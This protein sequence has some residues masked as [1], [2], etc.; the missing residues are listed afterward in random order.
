MKRILNSLI[1]L[2]VILLTSMSAM[3]TPKITLTTSPVSAASISQGSNYNV[4]YIVKA[5]VTVE[6]VTLNLIAFT[7]TGT[8]DSNDFTNFYIYFNPTSPSMTGATYLGYTPG[9]F[10]GPHQF[11]ANISKYMAANDEG[12]FLISGNVSTTATD[13]NTAQVNGATNPVTFT[14][15]TI[16]TIVNNQNNGAGVQ[17]IEAADV[18]LSSSVVDAATIAQGSQYNKVYAAK[19][20]VKT[21]SVVVNSIQFTLK[22]NHDDNDLTYAYVYFNPTSP[23][24]N[25]A[26]YLGYATANFAGPHTYAVSI[27]KAMNK[28]DQGYFIISVTLSNTATDEHTVL[29]NGA[30]DPV[31]FGYSTAPNVTN[32]QSNKS[33]TQT[34]QAADVTLTSSVIDSAKHNQ[35]STYNVMYAVKASVKTQPVTMN[36][37]QFTV[38]GTHD[39]GDLTY[40]YVYFNESSPDMTGASYLGYAYANYSAPHTYTVGINKAMDKGESGYFIIS[41]SLTND[42]TDGHTFLINGASNPVVFT[43]TTGPNVTDKQSNKA[44]KQTI[45]AADIT[46]T[47]SNVPAADHNQG[48]TYNVFYTTKMV[49]KTQPVT[50]NNIQFNLK[51]S[52]DNGDL[53]YVYVY[54]NPTSPDMTGASYLGYAYANFSGPH[55]YS[56]NINK[57]MAK[58]DQGYFILSASLTNNATD[59]HTFLM[60]GG[61]DPVV[62]GFNTAPNITNNQSNKSKKQT[63][64]AADITLTTPTI[65]AGNIAQGSTYNEVYAAKMNV[66]TEPVTVTNVQFTLSGNHDNNDLTYVYVYYNASAPEV[67]GGTYLGYATATYAA[68]HTYSVGINK[69]MNAGDQGYFI[70]AVNVNATASIGKTVK[71]NG[72]TDPMVFSY[73]TAPNSTNS[74]SNKTGVQ[75]IVSSFAGTNNPVKEETESKDIYKTGNIYPNPASSSFNFTVTGSKSETIKAQLTGRTG[76]VMMEKSYSIN[77]SASR[78]TVNVASIPTGTYYLVLINSKGVVISRQQVYIQ[79]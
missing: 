59:G 51:G 66:T 76:N 61:T 70:V 39:N 27:Y 24:M 49:V 15:S 68:P 60:N 64:Q 16:T 19:M 74:Q 4:V 50:V 52:H 73:T 22:G 40:V 11:T 34:I 48:S 3:A 65:A 25:G 43:Y 29:M 57:A 67:T 41:A 62:F 8:Y 20:V 33:K 1:V 5:K 17:T 46:L 77:T 47:T 14:Y 55:T 35:G 72:A 28:G 10:A 12:Y 6:A 38:K 78:F 54:F 31:V 7:L 75:T 42:A 71:E 79:H 69:A 37:I 26:S 2:S 45:E 58:G 18:T 13:N 32:N 23:D 53:T 63:I 21:Q 36:S 9:N 30:T 44:Q 56:L